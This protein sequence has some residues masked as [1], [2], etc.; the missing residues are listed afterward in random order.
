MDYKDTIFF[1]YRIGAH[2]TALSQ[3]VTQQASR[4]NTSK[5]YEENNIH[6]I[7]QMSVPILYF[8]SQCTQ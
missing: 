3:E 2:F 6:S 4:E 1:S 8:T 7:V 5:Q